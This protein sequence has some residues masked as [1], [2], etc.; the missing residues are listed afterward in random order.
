MA[1]VLETVFFSRSL[2]GA[3]L[4]SVVFGWGELPL[5]PRSADTS[6]KASASMELDAVIIFHTH[7]ASWS[8]FTVLQSHMSL[9]P[10][11]QGF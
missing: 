4:Q 9:C 8:G 7:Q 5:G 10:D 2:V 3:F 6:R 11:S 1:M